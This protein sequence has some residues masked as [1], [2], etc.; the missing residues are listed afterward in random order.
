LHLHLQVLL[1]EE[2]VPWDHVER[3][4]IKF[5]AIVHLQDAIVNESHK[6]LNIVV[7]VLGKF[8]HFKLL[9]QDI[10]IWIDFGVGKHFSYRHASQCCVWE[11]KNH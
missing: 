7:I 2:V 8:C 10:N 1:K 11:E 9:Y 5:I 6:V 4:D 3:A